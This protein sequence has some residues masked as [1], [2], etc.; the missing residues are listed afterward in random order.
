MSD[1]SMTID[2]KA[3]AGESSFGVVNPATG[4]VFAQAPDCSKAQ[5]GNAMDA[6]QRAFR[7][8]RTDEAKRRQTLIECANAMKS[9]AAEIAQVLTQEQGKPLAKAM[10]EVF[11]GV[12]WFQVTA[13]LQIPVDVIADGPT[14][15]SMR[16]R[17]W[18]AGVA[19]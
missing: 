14:R 12:V 17:G 10:E 1:L 19:I 6:A 4:A 2:G 3:V 7:G 5:L 9:R 16:R 18:R 11:G 13:G 8:W 15:G